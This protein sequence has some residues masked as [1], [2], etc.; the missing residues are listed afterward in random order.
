MLAVPDADGELSSGWAEASTLSS[1]SMG[2]LSL[3]I[4][5]CGICRDVSS[6]GVNIDG[7]GDVVDGS[8]F[9]SAD[10]G[11]VP[12]PSAD[13]ATRLPSDC[14]LR[15]NTVVSLLPSTC[16]MLSETIASVSAMQDLTRA[17]SSSMGMTR[18][19]CWCALMST[20]T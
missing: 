5:L 18:P 14:T 17:R 7:G 13:K 3:S 8:C 10:G 2:C 12:D 20:S 16:V 6:V 4:S 19:R 1:T 15:R 11:E 9:D